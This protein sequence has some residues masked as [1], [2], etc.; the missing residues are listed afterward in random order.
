MWRGPTRT[1]WSRRCFRRSSSGRGT[2]TRHNPLTS[3]VWQGAW[4]DPP[5]KRSIIAGIQLDNSDVITFHSYAEPAGFEARVAELVPLQR[6]IVCTEYLARSLGSSRGGGILPIAQRLDVGAINWG[7]GG[8]QDAD[9]SAVG[10]VGSPGS[11]SEG[12]VQRSPGP[13]RASLPGRRDPRDPAVDAPL[14]RAK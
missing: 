2:S 13:G 6:P 8:G 9:V 14:V 11:G 3:G 4:A 10:L 7:P 1:T 12:V 5:G